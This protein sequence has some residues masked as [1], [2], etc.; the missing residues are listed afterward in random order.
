VVIQPDRG[1]AQLWR[2]LGALAPAA[3]GETPLAHVLTEAGAAMG[4]GMT[5]VVVTPAMDVDWVA[6]LLG[7]AHRGLSSSA[8][9]LDPTSFGDA[10]SGADSVALA[11]ILADVGI[12]SY[13]IRQGQRFALISRRDP[14][15]RPQYRPT[16]LGRAIPIAPGR[17]RQTGPRGQ[18]TPEW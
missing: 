3:P 12:P 5:A 8:I 15:R 14:R 1:L 17:P 13:V 4:R 9:L 10:S 6:S 2:I 7:L 16:V 11:G 18:R